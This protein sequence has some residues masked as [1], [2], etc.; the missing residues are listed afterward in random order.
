ME[1]Q[2][3]IQRIDGIVVFSITDK[4]LNHNNAASLKEKIF[5]E[6]ADGNTKI[7]L[8]LHQVEEMD[9]SGLGV[10][11]FG[12]RQASRTGGDIILVAINPGVQSLLRIAQLTRVFEIFDTKDEAVA[13]FSK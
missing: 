4:G 11:T 13:A 1:I 10:L 3:D 7:I 5:L 12:K 2:T 9:T 6:I 8:D